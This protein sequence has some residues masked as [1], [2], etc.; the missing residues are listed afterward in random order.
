MVLMARAGHSLMEAQAVYLYA[1]RLES[2]RVAIFYDDRVTDPEGDLRAMDL[3]V[4]RMEE[5]TGIRLRAKIYWVRGPLLGRR[6]LCCYGVAMGSDESPA[7]AIDRHELAHALLYQHYS[8]D[9][10]PPT[11]L[12]EGWAESQSVDSKDLADRA[13]EL[14]QLLAHQAKVPESE[15]EHTLDRFVDR[16]GFGRLLRNIRGPE[17]GTASY[18]RELTDDF[19]YHRGSGPVYSMGGA[20]VSFLLR[21]YGTPRFMEFYFACRPGTFEAECRRVF[22]TDLDSLEREFWEDADRLTRGQLPRK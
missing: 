8:P 1:H 2:E 10:D 16:E 13:I 4:A 11:L 21:T 3:H 18:L 14:R 15:R 5:M 6:H 22:G 20:F 17:G 9:T 12:S 7:G 19:W